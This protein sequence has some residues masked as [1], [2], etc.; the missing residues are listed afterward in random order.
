[1]IVLERIKLSGPHLTQKNQLLNVR[2]LR[3]FQ[4]RFINESAKKKKAKIP[5]FLNLGIQE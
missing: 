2:I 1:M 5:E 4:I 3:I